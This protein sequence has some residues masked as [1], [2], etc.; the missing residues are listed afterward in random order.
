MA[1][2]TDEIQK[3][4]PYISQI[5]VDAYSTVER[6]KQTQYDEGV[7]RIDNAFSQIAGL[8]VDEKYS[9]YVNSALGKLNDGVKKIAGSDFSNMQLVNQI[10]GAARSIA[11]DPII[12]NGVLSAANHKSNLNQMQED[13]KNGKL[14]PDNQWD[15]SQQYAQWKLNPDLSMPFQGSYYTHIDLNKKWLDVLK[16]IN[17]SAKLEDVPF[18]IDGNGNVD[19]SKMATAMVERGYKGVSPQQIETA[20]RSSMDENDLNQIRI[21]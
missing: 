11:A 12:Q 19:Y 16:S 17:P 13:K 6:Y 3:F 21:S 18:E 5:P 1:S 10:E 14:S 20:I 7:Q 2:F 4:N 8:P 15:Y 9:G